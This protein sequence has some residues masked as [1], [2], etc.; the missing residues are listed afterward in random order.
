MRQCAEAGIVFTVVPSNSYYLRTL[1]P[2]EWVLT[3]PIRHMPRH[4]IK[5]HPNS[6]HPS[7]H[8]VAPTRAWQME[9]R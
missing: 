3:H 8:H 7:F 5:I 6:D 2:E 4:G 1:R 9:D